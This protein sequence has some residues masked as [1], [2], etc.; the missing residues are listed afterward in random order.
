MTMSKCREIYQHICDNLDEDLSSPRCRQIKKHIDSCSDCRAY[1]DSLKKTV[2]LYRN[3]PAPEVP[4][5]THA[6]LLK[7]IKLEFSAVESKK[8]RRGGSKRTS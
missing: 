5:S 1:L 8:N 2:V 3:V 7:T 6:K 4:R